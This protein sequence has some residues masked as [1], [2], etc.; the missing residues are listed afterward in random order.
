MVSSKNWINDQERGSA[1]YLQIHGNFCRE[2]AA[3][4]PTSANSHQL[5]S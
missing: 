4:T 2:H 5:R 1:D 3:L